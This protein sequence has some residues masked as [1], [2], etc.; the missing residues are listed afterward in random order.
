MPKPCRDDSPLGD[1]REQIL[2]GVKSTDLLIEQPT[3]FELVIN[4]KSPR[5]LASPY[6]YRCSPAPMS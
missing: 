4:L 3:N 1:V 2:K 6:L 5:R